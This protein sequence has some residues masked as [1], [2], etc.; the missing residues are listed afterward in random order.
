MCEKAVIGVLVLNDSDGLV[1]VVHLVRFKSR[2]SRQ[3][4]AIGYDELCWP[5]QHASTPMQAFIADN[6]KPDEQGEDATPPIAPSALPR[7]LAQEFA[8]NVPENAA[9]IVGPMSRYGDGDS[10]DPFCRWLARV[11]G[12]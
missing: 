1:P 12:W 9:E 6:G 5:E 4:V 2:T 3:R 11:P 10:R 8:V 7:W